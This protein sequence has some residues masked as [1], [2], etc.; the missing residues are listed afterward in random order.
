MR[1]RFAARL[2]QSLVVVLLVTVISFFVIRL[3][4]ADP[5][6]YD[7][8]QV[9]AAT[10]EFWRKQFGY[11]R[12]L[13]EQFV[14]YVGSVAHGQLGYS[15]S[16]HEPVMSALRETMPRTLLLMSVALF[17]SFAI[18]VGVGVT[19]AARRGTWFDRIVSP[20]LLIC[21]S[22]PDF[23]FALLMALLFSLWLPILPASGMMDPAMHDFMSPAGKLFDVLEH[24]ILPSVT[25]TLLT[26]A[27]I[28]RYQRTAMLE[29]LNEDFVR[30]ARAK[31]A[32]ER[33]TVWRHALRA[34][35][36]PIITLFG[37]LF[38]ALL[39][40]AVFVEKVF[41]W[42][43]M[44][45]LAADA[46]SRQDYDLVTAAAILGAVM[47]AI[48]TLLADLLLPLIDPRTRD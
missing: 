2:L 40:G 29:V 31:G 3:G 48:G 21:Y 44:G 7:N 25:L 4:P 11:D 47:V 5:F 32:S 17:L 35:L 45:L 8:P 1:R 23:W 37:L 6:A 18:G 46:V 41:A 10:R 33:R 28:A 16:R 36:T 30:T 27:A 34:G 13:T 20:F 38:P 19:Q 42:P 43:G 39:G 14:R 26:T 24:L 12:P 9:S 22:L 15:W